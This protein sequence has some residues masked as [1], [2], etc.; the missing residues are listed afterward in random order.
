MFGVQATRKVWH[1][2]FGLPVAPVLLGVITAIG[3]GLLR[4]MLAG[5]TTLLMRTE[6]YAIPISFG[7]ILYTVV[8]ARLPDHGL[9]AASLCILVTFALRAAAIRWN[10]K[11]PGWAR[12]TSKGKA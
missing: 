7:C 3:G 2:E 1:L 11:V 8:L 4:D 12:T 10:L 5:R 6:L 9:L